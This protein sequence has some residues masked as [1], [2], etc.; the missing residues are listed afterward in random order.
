MKIYLAEGGSL[1]QM[2]SKGGECRNIHL[3]PN[4]QMLPKVGAEKDMKIYLADTGV[5][6]GTAMNEQKRKSP[7]TAAEAIFRDTN[8]L[9]SFYYCDSFTERVILPNC[10]HF[11][12][13]SGAFT[14]ITGQ[15]GK[16]VDWDE[17]VGRYI[18]FIRRNK[19]DRYFELDIDSVVGYDRVKQIRN[20]LE[21]ETGRQC[22][23][24]WHKSR[25]QAEFLKICDEYK[26]VAIGGIV[27]KEIKPNEY[28]VFT[29]LIKEAHKMGAK[30]HGLG[31]TSLSSLQKYHFDSV[32]STAWTSGNRFGTTYKFTGN[33]LV[34]CKKRDGLRIADHQALSLHN[35]TEWKK[36]CNWAETHL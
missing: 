10:K 8:I 6:F 2:I 25:G 20:R 13:D 16:P 7:E 21:R 32:D 11:L 1:F 12:L 30:I 19:V 23:P 15:K 24:V 27:S 17:Y 4:T 36:F 3:V 26:Y 9:Q 14:F 34:M 22:I 31:F 5:R 18:D 33:G 35:F 28:P 29:H